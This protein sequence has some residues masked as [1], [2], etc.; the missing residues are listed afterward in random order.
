[1]LPFLATT[2][3]PE[4]SDLIENY[5]PF[6][7][8]TKHNIEYD[9]IVEQYDGKLSRIKVTIIVSSYDL[10][11]PEIDLSYKSPPIKG[12]VL[13][14]SLVYFGDYVGIKNVKEFQML[15]ET[16]FDESGEITKDTI[17]N[18]LDP[19]AIKDEKFVS[20]MSSYLLEEVK[21]YIDS[22]Q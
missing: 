6:V 4:M 19:V 16:W 22:T 15:R 5:L 13:K 17:H 12:V 21:K 11:I 10:E 1:M 18:E 9:V 14:D 7:K 2:Q 3:T 8:Q 20:N